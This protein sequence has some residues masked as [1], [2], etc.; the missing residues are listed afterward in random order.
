MKYEGQIEKIS[1]PNPLLR[2]VVK[3]TDNG[4]IE[5][6]TGSQRLHLYSGGKISLLDLAHYFFLKYQ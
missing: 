4:G 5:G 1:P 3:V 2:C 6:D